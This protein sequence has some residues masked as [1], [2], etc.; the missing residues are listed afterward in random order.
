M[1]TTKTTKKKN[2]GKKSDLRETILSSYREQV[3]M[4][5]M[6]PASVF[7]FMRELGEGEGSF[8]DYFASF[9]ALEKGIWKTYID[10]T[11]AA[12]ESDAAYAEYNAREKLLAFYYTLLEMMKNDRSF[13]K[14]SLDKV[15]KPDVSPVILKLF[16]ERFMDYTGAILNEGRE[17]EEIVDRPVISE[18]YKDGIWLQMMFLLR[19]WLKDDSTGFTN[20]DAAV[21]KSVNLS[22]ELMGKGP[23]DQMIDFAKFLYHN[24]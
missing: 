6:P 17:H 10:E 19:F 8:Y 12:L 22:F 24:R 21:E 14:Y 15:K 3:L 4:N 11:I 20:T 18:R 9:E 16:K 13:V 7:Q 1:A 5:N 2:T 23:L